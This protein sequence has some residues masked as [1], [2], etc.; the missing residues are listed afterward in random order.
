MRLAAIDLGSNSFHLLVVETRPDGSFL[1]IV[2]EKEMLRLGDV[3]ARDKV[4]SPE[5]VER[6]VAGLRRLKA[7]A[8]SEGVEEIVAVGTAALREAR[9]GAAVVE[10]LEEATG[11]EIEV[12]SG[13]REAQ[14]I[15]GAVRRS[16]VLEPSP[17]LCVDLGGGSLEL[18]VSLD[19]ELGFAASLHL[20]VGRL[21]AEYFSASRPRPAEIARAREAITTA[22][23]PLARR[24]R[25]FA[26]ALLVGSSGTL[27]ALARLGAAGSDG[28]APESINQLHVARGSLEAVGKA[29]LSASLE[30]RQAMP[31]VESRRAELLPA[32]VL[33]LEALL[34]LTG[35]DGL[36]IS[37]W[38]LRE[39]L[40]IDA[41]TRHDPRELAGTTLA[42][43]EASVA[44][45]ARRFRWREDHA[46]QVERLAL[47]LFDCT[48]ALHGL[49]EAQRE[50]LAYAA[51]LHDIGGVL[52]PLDHARHTAY[53]IENAGLRGF[54][55]GEIATLCCLGRFHLKG[56]PKPSYRPF[57]VLSSPARGQC[58]ALLS[59]L[60]VAD[61]LDRSYASVVE[62]L[63]VVV[64][65][66]TVTLGVT[67]RGEAE[68][69]R[70]ALWRR[71][72]LFEQLFGVRIELEVTSSEADTYIPALSD[73]VG[74]G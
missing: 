40:V 45:L 43:R 60:R 39:G 35:L 11:I 27:S 17:A 28:A 67:A 6:A 5:S 66:K 16:V 30:E 10:E 73:G 69:E 42:I 56:T 14:L 59:L 50:L 54:A 41:I 34:D 57:A 18:M 21:T 48:A 12:V 58:V 13:L 64:T 31:G 24:I 36:T 74:L 65:G 1:P 37:E 53:L 9:N 71:G 47:R 33:V 20:G 62:R 55:P 15:F 26:P 3:V 38:A 72:Q 61:C 23:G 4:L 19:G 63:D 70:W 29:L 46:H 44:T 2:A 49:G 22:L 51:R 32:G 68:L 8:E 52:S 7:L 25:S